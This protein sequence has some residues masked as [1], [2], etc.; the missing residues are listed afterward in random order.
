MRN[1]EPPVPPADEPHRIAFSSYAFLKALAYEALPYGPNLLAVWC[2]ECRHER[3][4]TGA[5]WRMAQNRLLWFQPGNIMVPLPGQ[6]LGYFVP[7]WA[8]PLSVALWLLYDDVRAAIDLVEIFTWWSVIM[9]RHVTVAIKYGFLPRAE[10]EAMYL[11]DYDQLRLVKQLFMG[12]WASP[13]DFELLLEE[14]LF[15]A[16]RRCEVDLHGAAVRLHPPAAAAR[17]RASSCASVHT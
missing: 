16:A 15:S 13:G 8:F 17:V 7:N 10:A 9:L 6:L 1:V 4:S 3:R 2:F 12:G 5:A 14:E 11:P